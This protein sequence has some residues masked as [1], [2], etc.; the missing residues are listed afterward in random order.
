MRQV[1][2]VIAGGV[3]PAA[4]DVNRTAAGARWQRQF[5]VRLI[6]QA[7]DAL[8]FEIG[9]HI[10]QCIALEQIGTNNE[11]PGAH[12]AVAAG[13]LQH[14][15]A[16]CLPAREIGTIEGAIAPARHVTLRLQRA[17]QHR[18]IGLIIQ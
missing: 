16:R 8:A 5:A 2:A 9:N 15:A 17:A 14:V 4:V 10:R 18:F 13:G 6:E 3:I 12:I 7:G 11:R 1:H